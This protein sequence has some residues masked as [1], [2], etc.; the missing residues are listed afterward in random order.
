MTCASFVCGGGSAALAEQTEGA[1]HEAL[2]TG[3]PESIEQ[4]GPPVGPIA[5]R[6][7]GIAVDGDR[8]ANPRAGPTEG[9]EREALGTEQTECIEQ[10]DPRA[11]PIAERVEGIEVGGGGSEPSKLP[12]APK[13]ASGIPAMFGT[14][15][16]SVGSP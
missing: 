15:R 7:E 3:Q 2:G 10:E 13:P 9:I 1:E 14:E 16:C 8:H 4:D 6:V 11:G 5:E 12:I